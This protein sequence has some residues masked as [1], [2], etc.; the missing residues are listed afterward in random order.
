MIDAEAQIGTPGADDFDFLEVVRP[1][2]YADHLAA[3]A[4][5]PADPGRVAK[6]V[7]VGF[8]HGFEVVTW[9]GIG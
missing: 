2:V 6:S 9:R 4:P 7:S 5:V 1:D 8:P 3:D